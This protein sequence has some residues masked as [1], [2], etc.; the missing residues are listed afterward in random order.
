MSFMFWSMVFII[1]FVCAFVAG[2]CSEAR[3]KSAH[4]KVVKAVCRDMNKSR[5]ET[6]D[7]LTFM[8][9]D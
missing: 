6:K 7:V 8:G 2:W 4:R 5:T 1:G 9:L 3:K